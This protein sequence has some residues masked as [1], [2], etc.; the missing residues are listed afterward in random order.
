MNRKT[1][2][3]TLVDAFDS[4]TIKRRKMIGMAAGHRTRAFG[5]GTLVAG[6]GGI[7]KNPWKPVVPTADGLKAVLWTSDW[8]P[9]QGRDH[10]PGPRHRPPG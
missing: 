2:A 9:V 6:I 3:A 5:V 8:T 10:L 4:S 1:A 7:I